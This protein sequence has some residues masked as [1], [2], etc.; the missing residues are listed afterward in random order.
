[1]WG[2]CFRFTRFDIFDSK[3]L[4][5]DAVEDFGCALKA[6]FDFR[7]FLFFFNAFVPF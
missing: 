3:W 7:I 5:V 1:M 6:D 2:V 4:D